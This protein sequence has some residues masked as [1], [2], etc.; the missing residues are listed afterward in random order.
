MGTSQGSRR[1]RRKG[2]R[3]TPP[4]FTPAGS[5]DRDLRRIRA[6]LK[7]FFAGL[8][9]LHK[10][11]CE[12][13]SHRICVK[14]RAFQGSV[15]RIFGMKIIM[16]EGEF[17]ME[18]KTV[19]VRKT[20]L[21]DE[22]LVRRCEVLYG[23][24]KVNSFSQFVKQAL[25]MYIDYLIGLNH[26][27]FIS[28]ELKQAIRDEV[29]PLA[30]RLSKGLYRYAIELDMICQIIAYMEAEFPPGFLEIIRGKANER[31]AK[32]RGNIDVERLVMDRR[33]KTL[34]EQQMLWQQPSEEY[35]ELREKSLKEMY[36][37]GE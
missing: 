23:E 12:A 37:D 11:G 20:V 8:L 22:E 30:S 3:L 13:L 34:V 2:W 17:E 35:L 4:C 27:P 33:N 25:Q 31:V 10:V 24:A 32:M 18:E 1:S 14:I 21:L 28:E 36:Q 15:P 9:V 7:A 6:V 5:A 29:R 26:S 16:Q 19:G